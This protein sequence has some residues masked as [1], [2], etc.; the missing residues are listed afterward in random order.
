MY[1]LEPYKDKNHLSS[2]KKTTVL[3]S[4]VVQN[5][6]AV[7]KVNL[8]SSKW[9]QVKDAN[10]NNL[11]QIAI[12]LHKKEVFDYLLSLDDYPLRQSRPLKRRRLNSS[13]SG[14]DWYLNDY[15]A[16]EL[17]KKGVSHDSFRYYKDTLLHYAIRRSFIKV[18]KCC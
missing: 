15:F 2:I 1:D 5:N 17:L 7:L 16:S 12:I 18:T 11:L 6:V 14:A 13:D 9:Y 8:N 4:A 3:I 10:G